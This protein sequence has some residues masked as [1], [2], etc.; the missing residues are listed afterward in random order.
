MGWLTDTVE[1]VIDGTVAAVKKIGETASKAHSAYCGDKCDACGSLGE[2][3]W[4]EGGRYGKKC[5]HA[6]KMRQIAGDD[7]MTVRN[8]VK[9]YGHSKEAVP[10]KE[11]RKM[12]H[13]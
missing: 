3:R 13:L 2:V 7:G 12:K 11:R 1:T 8:S 10:N 4:V 9:K 6:T 5:G